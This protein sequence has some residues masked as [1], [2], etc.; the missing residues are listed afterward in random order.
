MTGHLERETDAVGEQGEQAPIP[1]ESRVARES[2]AGEADGD[3]GGKGTSSGAA[4]STNLAGP[5]WRPCWRSSG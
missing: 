3:P 5:G 4:S 2:Q 1:I